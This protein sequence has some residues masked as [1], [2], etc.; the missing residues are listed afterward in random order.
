MYEACE[1]MINFRGTSNCYNF[2]LK[3]FLR[4]DKFLFQY[5]QTLNFLNNIPF[6][7]TIYQ[8]KS[9]YTVISKLNCT[10]PT[11]SIDLLLLLT[12]Y[13]HWETPLETKS[14]NIKAN[15]YLKFIEKIQYFKF[16][17][18]QLQR[19]NSELVIEIE[20]VYWPNI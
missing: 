9:T 15:L 2:Y 14:R 18:T 10:D 17:D 16:K 4:F 1:N 6:P 20:G 19:N 12:R 13:S 5:V 8:T 11:A 3:I 7:S